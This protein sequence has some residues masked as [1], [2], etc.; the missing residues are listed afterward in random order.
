MQKSELRDWIKKRNLNG[1][2]KH[3]LTA[4]LIAMKTKWMQRYCN[5]LLEEF[6]IEGLLQCKID[7]VIDA[8]GHAR[9]TKIY[10]K[11]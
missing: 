8:I 2:G 6:V 4:R 5:L 3:V 10:W 7:Y 1:E 11:R 9:P